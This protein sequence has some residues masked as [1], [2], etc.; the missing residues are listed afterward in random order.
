MHA[1]PTAAA[2]YYKPGMLVALASGRCALIRASYDAGSERRYRVECKR[3]DFYDVGA[4]S[5]L[6]RATFNRDHL[7]VIQGGRQ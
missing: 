6:G 2:L 4:K 7:R 3:G 5:I 1:D